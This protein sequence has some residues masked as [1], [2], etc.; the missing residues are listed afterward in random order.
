MTAP[1]AKSRAARFTLASL[2]LLSVAV[3]LRAHNRGDTFPPRIPLHSF[4]EQI[5]AW[6]GKDHELPEDQL[7]IL[8]YPEYVLRDYSNQ[9]E[10]QTS[11]N[12]FLAYYKSQRTGETPHSPQNC[13]PGNGWWPVESSRIMLSM[14]NHAPF[15]V[16]RYVIAKGDARRLVL[17]WFWA[18]DRGVASEYLNKYYLVRDSIRLNRSDGS[19]IRFLSDMQP[20]ETAEAAQQRITPLVTSVLPMINDYIPR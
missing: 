5:G 15:P 20:G 13:L 12:L 1:M 4:P 19:M 18:H 7:G 11:V 6:R 3:F 2:L 16:N 14:P 10:P 8:G 9:D 17:Y